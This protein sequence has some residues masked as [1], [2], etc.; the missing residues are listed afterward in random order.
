MEAEIYWKHQC[1]REGQRKW[2]VRLEGKGISEGGGER[3]VVSHRV[4]IPV[5]ACVY[6]H[7]YVCLC[8][9]RWTAG[10]PGLAGRQK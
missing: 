4:C 2:D 6:V 3:A 5:Y 10:G 1:L 9:G 7:V 8:G